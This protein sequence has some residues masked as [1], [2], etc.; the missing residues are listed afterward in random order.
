[1]NRPRS[2]HNVAE[3][4]QPFRHR[5]FQSSGLILCAPQVPVLKQYA[6]VMRDSWRICARNKGISTFDTVLS[7]SCFSRKQRKQR[8]QLTNRGVSVAG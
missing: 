5:S 8:K 4:P 6:L 3:T 1:M 2:N 7:R